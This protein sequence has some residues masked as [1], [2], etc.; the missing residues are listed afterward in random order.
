MHGETKP[1][2][3]VRL[4]TSRLTAGSAQLP[5]SC[6][7]SAAPQPHS[8]IMAEIALRGADSEDSLRGEALDFVVLDNWPRSLGT[9][10]GS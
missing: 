10:A 9:C 5:T 1:A 4:F 3:A 2:S 6:A 8:A 7:L